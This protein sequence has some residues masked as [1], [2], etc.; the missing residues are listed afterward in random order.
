MKLH[1]QNKHI[2]KLYIKDKSLYPFIFQTG[3]LTR[4][5]QQRCKGSF[6]IEIKSESW[7]YPMSDEVQLIGS[8]EHERTFIRESYLKCDTKP[9]VYARTIIPRKTLTGKYKKLTMLG[10]K[11]LG[12]ILFNDNSS[13]RSDMQYARV[14]PDCTLYKQA[15]MVNDVNSSLWARKSLFYIKHNPLLIIEVFLPELKKCIQN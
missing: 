7:Q 10:N 4:Y 14:S 9:L 13:F 2:A 6:N 3:S 15:F 12:E 11:P 1:W 5:I 8:R